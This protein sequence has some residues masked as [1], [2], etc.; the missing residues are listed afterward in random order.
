[1]HDDAEFDAFVQQTSPRMLARAVMYCG[2]RQNAE[3]AVQEAYI[4]AYRHWASLHAPAA[5]VETV[6]RRR[7]AREAAR[8]WSRWKR[9]ELDLPVPAVATVEEESDALAVLRAVS[10]LPPR[11][12]QV[13]IMVCLEGM[14]YRQVADELGTS[15]GAVGANLAKAREKLTDLLGR[16]CAAVGLGD[17]LVIASLTRPRGTASGS[18]PLLPALAATESWL[19]RG[20]ASDPATARRVREAIWSAVHGQR[21]T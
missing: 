13:V 6:V 15:T 7:L 9:V 21:S 19:A 18:D 3:D 10:R 20:F 12:R 11:Q 5:W 1:M 2:H 14:T 8:W 16:G 4:E 17:P